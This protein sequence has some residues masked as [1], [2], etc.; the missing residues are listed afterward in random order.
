MQGLVA[1]EKTTRTE[2]AASSNLRSLNL[3]YDEKLDHLRFFAAALII[4]YHTFPSIFALV[5]RINCDHNEINRVTA[6]LTGLWAPANAL[7]QEGATAV[8]FF[9]TISGFLFARITENSNIS[10]GKFYFNRF[11]RIYPLYM[12]F[13]LLSLYLNPGADPLK[14]FLMSALTFQNMQGATS[15]FFT[16]S[17]LW[18]IAVE[19]QIYLIFP[20]LLFSYRSNGLKSILL[21]LLAS[22]ALKA[23][24]FSLPADSSSLS[25]FTTFGRIDQFLI[26]M[27]LGYSFNRSR[28][29]LRHPLFLCSAAGIVLAVITLKHLLNLDNFI[30]G[31]FWPAVEAVIWGFLLV[32]YC[33]SSFSF[34]KVISSLLS[35]LGTISYSIYV[36][37]FPICI[38]LSL[39]LAAPLYAFNTTTLAPL[40][41]NGL[42]AHFL[43]G[44]M[45][46][47][48]I[49]LPL[50]IAASCLTYYGIEKPFMNCRVKY[51]HPLN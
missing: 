18:S 24:A 21:M 38:L 48:L 12:T 27:A 49:A 25:N 51:T 4:V 9:L 3:K 8:G 34:P 30:T 41:G 10:T 29:K 32:S 43:I 7:V 39:W 1:I 37:H 42:H 50:T 22:V 17:H 6:S 26:G 46:P 23:L 5:H 15:Y 40:L 33:A 13:I 2:P 45:F 36:T 44:V 47:L 19:F 11:L 35:F 16:T 14:S 20:L 28:E 31:V